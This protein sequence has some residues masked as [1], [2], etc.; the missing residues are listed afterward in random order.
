MG[1]ISDKYVNEF[2]RVPTAYEFFSVLKRGGQSVFTK[3]ETDFILKAIEFAQ[4]HTEEALETGARNAH[5]VQDWNGNTDSEYVDYVIHKP[6]I[7]NAYPTENI[8]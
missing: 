6:S 1:A 5:I 2:G 7:L 3:R 4:M 8:K